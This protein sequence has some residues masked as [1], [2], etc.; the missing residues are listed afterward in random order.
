M[1]DDVGKRL[2]DDPERGLIDSGRHRLKIIGLFPDQ[3]HLSAG[4]P[5]PVHQIVEPS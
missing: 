4:Q 5:E 2:L 1:T 3:G